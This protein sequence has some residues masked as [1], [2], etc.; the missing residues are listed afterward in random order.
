MS[1]Q[2]RTLDQ[3]RAAFSHRKVKERKE[4]LDTQKADDYAGYVI[5][6]PADIRINGLGQ[7]LAQLLAAAKL[8]PSDPHR[9]V[10]NDLSEW[11]TKEHPHSPYRNHD[12]LL[13][14]LMERG[15]AEYLWA[16]GEAMTWLE[17]HKKLCTA[18]L[19]Q[20]EGSER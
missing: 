15:R 9:L 16:L 17:W 19:K 1:E 4:T 14:A 8:D 18:F 7:A 13:D 10:Y 12:D 3:L 5:R 2:E 20:P 6:L 11:L